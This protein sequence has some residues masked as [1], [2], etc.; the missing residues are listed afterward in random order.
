MKTMQKLVGCTITKK[1]FDFNNDLR[2]SHYTTFSEKT[3]KI[4]KT[5]ILPQ[6]PLLMKPLHIEIA[7][8]YSCAISMVVPAG[9]EPAISWMRTRRPGPLDD[10]TTYY[11]YNIDSRKVGNF[12]WFYPF[13]AYIIYERSAP[14]A[15]NTDWEAVPTIVRA[16]RRPDARLIEAEVVRRISRRRDARR[17]VVAIFTGVPQVTDTQIDVAAAHYYSLAEAL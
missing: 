2:H 5:V 3:R 13:S 4:H 15:T 8:P 11:Y 12:L 9:V 10:E 17:P 1:W 14:N 16:V 6:V 7:Q